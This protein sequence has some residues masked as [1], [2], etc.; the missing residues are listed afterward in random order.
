MRTKIIV[1]IRKGVIE[2]VFSNKTI[3]EIDLEVIDLDTDD[4]QVHD[5]CETR[6]DQIDADPM[7]KDLTE[8]DG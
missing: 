8:W 2:S 4:S 1:V 5:D 6:L 7:L 3:K